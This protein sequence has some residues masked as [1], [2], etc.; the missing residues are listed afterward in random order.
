M[1][2]P[3]R[4]LDSKLLNYPAAEITT[5]EGFLNLKP[6]LETAIRRNPPP[7]G[8]LSMAEA[9]LTQPEFY[10]YESGA[11][12]SHIDNLCNNNFQFQVNDVSP[13]LNYIDSRPNSALGRV[14]EGLPKEQAEYRV[15]SQFTYN[16]GYA[17]MNNV[18][19][20][21]DTSDPDVSSTFGVHPGQDHAQEEP[22]ERGKQIDCDNYFLNK[23]FDDVQPHEPYL[24]HCQVVETV[25]KELEYEEKF[26]GRPAL[27]D[28]SIRKRRRKPNE[29]NWKP[30]SIF[31][32]FVD[33]KPTNIHKSS[34]P[35]HVP[36]CSCFG[37]I[38]M[39]EAKAW[40][41]QPNKPKRQKRN[42]GSL[43]YVRPQGRSDVASRDLNF[44]AMGSI[45]H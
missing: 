22:Y 3:E 7:H 10:G 8:T 35:D 38:N 31:R 21:G 32:S 1:A 24:V 43:R 23:T 37:R 20:Q 16:S 33:C 14:L 26:H 29:V 45:R 15:Q 5:S 40:S 17:F 13:S 39:R 18:P 44:F 42:D 2:S 6:A 25:R 30:E 11:L 36:M 41:R 9:Q 12:D 28:E 27:A 34:Y 19:Q 4:H